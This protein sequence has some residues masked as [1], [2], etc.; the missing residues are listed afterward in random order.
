M[1][2]LV[3][4]VLEEP[5]DL[6]AGQVDLVLVLELVLLDLVEVL[7]QVVDGVG[8][9]EVEL[10]LVLQVDVLLYEVPVRQG[11]QEGQHFQLDARLLVVG[12]LHEVDVLLVQRLVAQDVDR[13]RPQLVQ[14]VDLDGVLEVAGVGV[15]LA[16]LHGGRHPQ[17]RGVQLV[18]AARPLLHLRRGR[19][20]PQDLF[21]NHAVKLQLLVQPDQ[22]LQED[23][24]EAGGD[25]ALVEVGL[26][27]LRLEQRVGDL[28][29]PAGVGPVQELE[30]LLEEFVEL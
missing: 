26:V 25:K 4:L 8:E 19:R 5:A 21:R 28:V 27:L 10:L 15:A 16:A 22:F 12:G 3:D 18:R 29:H 20:E 13:V 17:L 6:L 1:V 9:D 14:L 30:V 24:G 2:E 7:D 23:A 11:R